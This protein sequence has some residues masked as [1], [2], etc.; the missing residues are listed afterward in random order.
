MCFPLVL[1]L[2]IQFE[3]EDENDSL[4]GIGRENGPRSGLGCQPR[5]LALG[6]SLYG[7][8]SCKG[9]R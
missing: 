5:A 9:I 6:S 8:L 2:V 4:V 3:D 7:N 1:V